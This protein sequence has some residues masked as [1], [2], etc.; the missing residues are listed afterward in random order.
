M[1]DGIV[2]VDYLSPFSDL[3]RKGRRQMGVARSRRYLVVDAVVDTGYV[4]GGSGESDGRE[5]RDHQKDGK[6]ER[7]GLFQRVFQKNSHLNFF[8]TAKR[9]IYIITHSVYNAFCR[10]VQIEFIMRTDFCKKCTKQHGTI[11]K[12]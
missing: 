7:E 8:C 9:Y 6:Y 10:D 11:W 1:A 12:K 2:S 3:H 4:F 5:H